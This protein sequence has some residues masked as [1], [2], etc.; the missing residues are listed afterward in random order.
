[1]TRTVRILF[2]TPEDEAL[3]WKPPSDDERIDVHSVLGDATAGTED[4]HTSKRTLSKRMSDETLLDEAD[5]T[6]ASIKSTSAPS[7]RKFAMF[8]LSKGF[9]GFSTHNLVIRKGMTTKVLRKSGIADVSHMKRYLSLVRL[10]ALK[11][12]DKEKD[13]LDIEVGS[14]QE[15]DFLAQSF[16]ISGLAVPDGFSMK[17]VTFHSHKNGPLQCKVDTKKRKKLL[18]FE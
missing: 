7:P 6:V 4:D 10:G 1:M 9:K 14:E 18:S 11:D 3:K 13:S 2:Y 8:N 5:Q 15:R 17:T 12:D 16:V